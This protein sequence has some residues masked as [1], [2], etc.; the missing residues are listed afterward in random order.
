VNT[1]SI[2]NTESLE[3]V[4]QY[5]ASKTKKIWFEHSKTVNITRHSKAWW[6]KDYRHSL[7]KYCQTQ[8]L[9]NWKDFKSMVKKSKCSFFDDKIEEIANKRC[10]LWKLMNWVRKRKLPVVEAIQYKGHLCIEPENL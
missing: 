5:L 7:D 8:S 10:S 2:H 9:E 6:N 3:E 1:T 4:V